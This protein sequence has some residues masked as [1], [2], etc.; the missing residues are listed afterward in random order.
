MLAP[1]ENLLIPTTWSWFHL[2]EIMG[3][4]SGGVMGHFYP[5]A[6]DFQGE[7]FPPS[8]MVTGSNSLG[9][10]EI[11]L[12]RAPSG[13]PLWGQSNPWVLKLG[14]PFPAAQRPDGRTRADVQC[15]RSSKSEQGALR[16]GTHTA[17]QGGRALGQQPEGNREAVLQPQEF[18]LQPE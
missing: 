18:C 1:L 15:E 8:G 17:P 2:P 14:G 9:P 3:L 10:G 7:P 13:L 6:F 16:Q 11:V 4:L 5:R 12:S